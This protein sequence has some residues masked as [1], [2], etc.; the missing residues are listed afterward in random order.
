MTL[1]D[2]KGNDPDTLGKRLVYVYDSD[3]FPFYQAEFYH[4]YHNDFL[5]PAYGKEYNNL[6]QT[7]LDDGRI[8][9]TGCPDRV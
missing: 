1:V 6:A 2:G 3:K 5:S 8:K 4:Q 7:A 9:I